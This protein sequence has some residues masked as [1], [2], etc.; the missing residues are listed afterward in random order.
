MAEH[1]FTMFTG[2]SDGTIVEAKL[3]TKL[4]PKDALVKQTYS[5]VCSTDLHLSEKPCALGHEGVGIIEE[6]GA[7]AHLWTDLKIGD[8][9]G[10][11]WMQSYC[12]QCRSCL[13][14]RDGL[15]EKGKELWAPDN[16]TGSWGFGGVWDVT[17]LRKIP[18]SLE[19]KYAGPLMCAGATVWGAMQR[20]KI[21]S[22]HRVGVLGIGGL[23]HLA[24]QFLAK[25][26]CEVVVLSSSDRKK[27]EAFDLGATE[28]HTADAIKGDPE[29]LEPLT[30]LMVCTGAQPD[31]AVYMKIMA[32]AGII[33]PLTVDFEATPI[34][35]APTIFQG[36]NIIG[37]KVCD[38]WEYDAMFKFVVRHKVLPIIQEYPMTADGLNDAVRDLKQGKVRYR[39]VV[40]A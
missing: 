37:V 23:G 2:S 30:H 40:K 39:A 1:S 33:L 13:I 18:D 25:S 4:G 36:L 20:G 21:M 8:R 35:L 22:H 31:Y 29:G 27:Q 3:S 12:G 38:R 24:I 6:M 15:C 11:G 10:F 9:V 26:G 16:N 14:G 5:G 19:S 34:P 32:P 7:M 28:F 17:A